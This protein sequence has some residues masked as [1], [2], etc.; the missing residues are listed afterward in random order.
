MG[1]AGKVFNALAGT[2]PVATVEKFSDQM[3]FTPVVELELPAWN[4]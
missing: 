2:L 3:P 4:L 1:A